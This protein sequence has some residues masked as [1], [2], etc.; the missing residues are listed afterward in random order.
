MHVSRLLSVADASIPDNDR[1]LHVF[2]LAI[3]LFAV[4][5]PSVGLVFVQES[6]LTSPTTSRKQ[7]CIAG[8]G[9]TL[10]QPLPGVIVLG[11]DT[12]ALRAVA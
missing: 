8:Q 11:L 9:S 1:Q 12:L 6:C 5:M 3:P 2:V 10:W 7:C 4:H